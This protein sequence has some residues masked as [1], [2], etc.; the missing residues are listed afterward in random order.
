MHQNK[1]RDFTLCTLAQNNK[2]TDNV[3]IPAATSQRS[4]VLVTFPATALLP[5]ATNPFA[6]AKDGGALNMGNTAYYPS[7]SGRS[8]GRPI[9]RLCYPP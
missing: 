9:P 5:S 3:N 4:Q 7:Y 8:E 6:L 2:L 1:H